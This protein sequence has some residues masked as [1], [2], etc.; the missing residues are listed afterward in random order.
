[1]QKDDKISEET[2]RDPEGV[3][4]IKGAKDSR[5]IKCKPLRDK[6][7]SIFGGKRYVAVRLCGR[8]RP[9]RISKDVRGWEHMRPVMD[10]VTPQS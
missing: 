1:M 6:L 9:K 2:R 3:G 8:D 7:V 10:T 4:S 5:S